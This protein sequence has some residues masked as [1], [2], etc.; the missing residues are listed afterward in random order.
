MVSHLLPA[1]DATPL[2]SAFTKSL[3]V[4]PIGTGLTLDRVLLVSVPLPWPKPALGHDFLKPVGAAVAHS[5]IPTR[6]FAAEPWHLGKQVTIE[7]YER[8]GLDFQ[9]YRWTLDS[10]EQI[11]LTVDRIV[12]AG[13]GALGMAP[14]PVTVPTFLVC[15]QGSH[16]QCCGDFGVALA[17]QIDRERPDFRV[18][19]VS[20]TGGHRFAPTFLALPSGRMWAYA[21]LALVDRVASGS[22]TVDD[23]RMY[24]RGWLGARKGAEQVAELAA[25][26]ESGN[27]F[28]EPPT[29]QVTDGDDGAKFCEVVADGRTVHVGVRPGRE[30]PSIAC[31][32]PGGLPAK[33]GREYDWTVMVAEPQEGP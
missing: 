2:C 14:I 7:L 8:D 6:L 21:D 28:L 22:V 24:C 32:A 5:A 18:R 23:L 33:P 12:H 31:E 16:D 20:H 9:A 11:E 4:R 19:R 13:R 3:G 1:T 17:D 26:I 10:P 30:V 25:R 29:I 15:T 27:P